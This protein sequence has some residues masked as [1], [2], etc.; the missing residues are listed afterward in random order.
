MLRDYETKLSWILS[1][2]IKMQYLILTFIPISGNGVIVT[3][4]GKKI[5][6]IR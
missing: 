6:K 5:K 4:V 1:S 3:H 2:I